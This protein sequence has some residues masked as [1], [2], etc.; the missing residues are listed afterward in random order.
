MRLDTLPGDVDRDHCFMLR[1]CLFGRVA[2]KLDTH[3]DRQYTR[4]NGG[5][6]G[7]GDS[8]IMDRTLVVSESTMLHV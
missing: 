3:A 8:G 5:H 7:R 6:G 4:R 2:P 1:V